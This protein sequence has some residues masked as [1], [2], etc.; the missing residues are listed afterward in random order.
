MKITKKQAQRFTNEASKALEN[1]G[2]T[3]I[4]T[5]GQLKRY[6]LEL[7]FG[8]VEF[9]IWTEPSS[10]YRLTARVEGGKEAISKASRIVNGERP[11]YDCALNQFSGK[12]N[13]HGSN[14]EGML[15]EL[16]WRLS[17]YGKGGTYELELIQE[18]VLIQGEE[19]SQ[20]Y[21]IPEP[22]DLKVYD[23]GGETFDRFTVVYLDEIE[24][25]TKDGILY[26][27]LGMSSDP[28][29]P[30]G[31]AQH[32]SAM[33]GDH[34]GREIPFSSMPEDCRTCAIRSQPFRSVY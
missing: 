31:Y 18:P 12:W 4:G 14:V 7:C 13:I 9:S 34:L 23:N 26:S 27:C 6:S 28:F 15:A 3:Y 33:I 25:E 21:K 1:A 32:S 10:C 11:T 20:G 30:L 2:A 8:I 19:K 5:F 22:K 17:Y 29:N 16:S 24:R